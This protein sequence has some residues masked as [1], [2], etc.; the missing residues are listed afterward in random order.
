MLPKKFVPRSINIIKVYFDKHIYINPNFAPKNE[1]IN[2]ID[3]FKTISSIND[4]VTSR[5]KLETYCAL[6][7]HNTYFWIILGSLLPQTPPKQEFCHN[8]FTQYIPLSCCCLTSTR[9]SIKFN[10][11]ICYKT[12]KSHFGH[13]FCLKTPV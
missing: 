5:D 3:Y 8:S 12:E 11:A 7:Y 13:I 2:K 1:S 6:I 4:A 10:D 9:K